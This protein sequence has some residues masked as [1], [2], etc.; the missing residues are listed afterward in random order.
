MGVGGRQERKFGLFPCYASF[1]WREFFAG[2]WVMFRWKQEAWAVLIE[3][4][5]IGGDAVVD[6]LK[7]CSFSLIELGF[8]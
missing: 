5:V 3:V 4:V 1:R 2:D 7:L 6:V 8:P